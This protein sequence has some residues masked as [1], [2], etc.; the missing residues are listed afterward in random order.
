MKISFIIATLDRPKQL[1]E[2]IQNIINQNCRDEYEIIIIDQSDDESICQF[3]IQMSDKVK[4]I[5]IPVKGLSHARNV[6]IDVATGEYICLVDDD[7]I[8][9]DK[10]LEIATSVL[11]RMHP[12]IMGGLI[13]DPATG[14]IK[15]SGQ[16]SKIGYLKVFQAFQSPGMFIETKFAC[17]QKFDENFGIGA[18]Y[19]SGEET[20]IV[21]A[22]IKNQELVYYC[23]EYVVIHSVTEDISNIP[24]IKK[25]GYGAGALCKKTYLLYSRGWGIFY[26]ARIIVG[27]ICKACVYAMRR[28]FVGVKARDS[29]IKSAIKGF[30]NF[31]YRKEEIEQKQL[32]I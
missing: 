25:Y 20:D 31:D 18:Q 9:E 2:C 26:F 3:V 21:L 14:K 28:N 22:A 30:I 1:L 19:G 13:E 6:G 24:R 4:L 17:K 10:A 15:Y 16:S 12:T 27:G 32:L 8:F 5:H 29:R 11:Q 7:M 23:K